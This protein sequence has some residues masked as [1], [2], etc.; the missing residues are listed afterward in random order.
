[1]RNNFSRSIVTC[2]I[3]TAI[4]SL[5]FGAAIQ[6][7]VPSLYSAYAQP[8]ENKRPNILAIMGD[9]LGF[10]DIG[11]FGSEISTPNLDA[12]AKEGKIFTN[13]H[14]NPVCSPARV[15]FLTGVD[16]HIGGIGTMYENIAPNQVGK[17]GYET[18]INNR[19][20]TIAE[21]LRDAGY[22]T[23]MS[24]KW[25][26]SGSGN[27]N[28]SD[29]YDRGFEDVLTVLSS[30]AQHFNGDAYYFGGHP[31]FMRNGTE[32][33]RPNTGTYSNDLYTN[34]MLDQIK[35]HKDDGKPLF[36]YLSFQVGHSPKSIRIQ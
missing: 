18:Y 34:V 21:L 35:N 12:L 3:F 2:V 13:Y 7:R 30:G 20:F 14:T 24:G 9:D 33:P 17:P 28:G 31:I 10:S 4:I 26:L 23:L 22:D 29:P 36:M 8:S 15:A 32:V 16:N 25:H 11:S 19:V 5:V 1:M 6:T 27:K